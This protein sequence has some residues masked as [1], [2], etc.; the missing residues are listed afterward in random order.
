MY[1]LTPSK[2]LI[3]RNGEHIKAATVFTWLLAAQHPQVYWAPFLSDVATFQLVSY[4]VGDAIASPDDFFLTQVNQ[5]RHMGCNQNTSLFLT[6]TAP[7][8]FIPQ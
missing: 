2:I 3:K 1:Y 8:K 6:P 7:L 5:A 4:V